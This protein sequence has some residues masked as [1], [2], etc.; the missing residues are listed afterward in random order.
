MRPLFIVFI[1]VMLGLVACSDSATLHTPP[2]QTPPATTGGSDS[3]TDN[4][5]AD[6]PIPD[7]PV[8]DIPGSEN[9]TSLT[10]EEANALAMSLW[11]NDTLS[12]HPKGSCAGCHGADFFDLAQI[13][14]TDTDLRRRA[15][16]DGATQQEADALVLAVNALRQKYAMPVTNARA[17]R[18]FQPGGSVLLP[19]LTDAPHVAAVKR[20]IAFGQQLEPL[21]PTLFG[22]RI[23]SLEAAEK[24]RDELLDLA[25]GTNRAGANPNLLNLRNLPTGV[26]YP[27]WSADVHHG[28]SEGTFNDWI[29]DVAHDPKPERKA[30]WQALQ[31][32]YLADPSNDN[33]WKMYLAA[34]DM[35][36]TQLLDTCT[37]DGINPS[38]ACGAAPDF[39]QHKFLSALI[40]QH[41]LRLESLNRSDF[42]DGALAF[43][44]LDTLEVMKGRKDPQFLPGDMWEIGDRGRVMLEES[45]K[46]NTFK[47]NLQ[48]LGYP[49][50]VQNSIDP[51]RSEAT[52]QHQLRLAWFWIGFTF[53]P[54]FARIH[55]SNA[56]KVGEYMV[57]TLIDERMF[58]HNSFQTLMRL[59]TKG[60]LQEANM[61]RRNNQMGAFP[62]TPYFQMNYRYF[63]GYNRTVL[64][65]EWNESKKFNILIPEDLKVQSTDLFNRLTANGFRMS[66]YLY[67]NALDHGADKN[68]SLADLTGAGTGFNAMK[69]H[70]D[71]YESEHQ[72][73]DEALM[74]ALK[75]KLGL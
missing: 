53:D 16:I 67:M 28:A 56:T 68:G 10:T 19:E 33:F 73:A 23:D 69:A 42:A 75:T 8:T 43:S 50:F 20:D 11:R 9:P 30:E 15:M 32:A 26:L 38:L 59:V 21:L 61:E 54:S 48:K 25:E 1:V 40:G 55:A 14:S 7:T 41:M 31:D 65:Y 29:A 74:N 4:P 63:W 57:G 6:N 70:F 35:T 44:Y 27:L 2:T 58:T 49:E 24:A 46:A 62:T 45:S 13:G 47:T 66:M 22:S 60:S 36:A 52:E 37:M 39:N 64:D 17:F 3:G 71:A 34:K 5:V 51:E 12:K 18:P 72:A